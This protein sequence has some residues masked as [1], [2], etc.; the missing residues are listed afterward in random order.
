M[1]ILRH[2]MSFVQL[3]CPYIWTNTAMLLS[4]FVP[5][6]ENKNKILYGWANSLLFFGLIVPV[7]FS[8]LLEPLGKSSWV[9]S[10]GP[11]RNW[12]QFSKKDAVPV[13]E[14][15]KR[16]R[17]QQWGAMGPA[18]LVFAYS[19]RDTTCL[20][21]ATRSRCLVKLPMLTATSLPSWSWVCWIE[22]TK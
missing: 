8:S 16:S 5:N 7:A 19:Y 9:V 1:I 2:I 20:E 3:C 15:D 21:Q 14:K 22:S 10:T 4:S 6:S 11:V 12:E 17:K 13:W 18:L